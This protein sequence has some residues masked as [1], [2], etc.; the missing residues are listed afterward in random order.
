M[1]KAIATNFKDLL[2]ILIIFLMSINL[3][4]Q[5]K[6]VLYLKDGSSQTGYVTYEKKYVK[7]QKTKKDKKKKVEYHLLDSTTNYVSQ[8]AK[9]NKRKPKTYYFFPEGKKGKHYNAWE[10]DTKGEVSLYKRTVDASNGGMWMNS[11]GGTSTFVP[12]GSNKDKK[13]VIYRVKRANEPY[14]TSFGNKDFS[15]AFITIVDSFKNETARYFEDCPT[16]V[17]K[18]KKE[19]KGF[20]RNCMK[21]IVDYYNNQCN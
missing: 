10:V 9:N 18:I 11:T 15:A 7:F 12:T 21:E 6:M 2:L 1:K 3:Y 16:L 4:S 8:R 20:T 19:E 13:N 5:K 14:L 17:E